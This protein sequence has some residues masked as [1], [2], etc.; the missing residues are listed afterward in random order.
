M[1]ATTKGEW[2]LWGVVGWARGVFITSAILSSCSVCFAS[3]ASCLATCA[4]G[5]RREGRSQAGCPLH[6][7]VF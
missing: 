7:I 3:A 6:F 4:K 1:E 5:Q 2:R